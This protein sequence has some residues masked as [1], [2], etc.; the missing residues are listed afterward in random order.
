MLLE[1]V[2]SMLFILLQTM[3]YVESFTLL[4]ASKMIKDIKCFLVS[5]FQITGETIFSCS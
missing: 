1:T 4:K 3:F 2:A 5:L